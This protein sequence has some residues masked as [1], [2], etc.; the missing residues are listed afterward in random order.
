MHLPAPLETL[1]RNN[2]LQ[3]A[4]WALVIFGLALTGAVAYGQT[5]TVPYLPKYQVLTVVYAP[6]GSASSVTYG[7]SE[8]VGSSQS[9]SQNTTSS[10]NVATT[11]G[12]VWNTPWSGGSIGYTVST[13]YQVQSSSQSTMSIT[14]T[15][16][17][18]VA[19]AGPVSSALGVNHDNDVIYILLNPVVVTT[20]TPGASIPF[21]WVGLQYNSCDLTDAQDVTNVYQAV[22]GCDPNQFPFPDIVGI[23]VWCLKN[24]YYPGTSCTQ[25]LPY[26]SRWWDMVKW[27]INTST[28]LPLGPMLTLQDYADILSV[29]PFVTQTLVP[30]SQTAVNYCHPTYGVNLDPNDSETVSAVP[31]TAPPSGN[32]PSNFCGTPNN[33]STTQVTMQRFDAYDQVQYPEPGIN[34]QPQTYTGTLAYNQTSTLGESATYTSMTGNAFNVSAWGGFLGNGLS[35]SYSSSQSWSTAQGTAS[36]TTSGTANTASYSITGPQLTDNYTGPATF[37]VYKDNV[38]GTFAF[39]SDLQGLGMPLHLSTYPSSGLAGG[40]IN[41][42]SGL[43][44]P[45]S[46]Q[47]PEPP[48]LVSLSS[49]PTTYWAAGKAFSF[50]GTVTVCDPSKLQSGQSCP[51]PDVQAIILTNNSPNQMTMVGPAV[52]FS[53]PGFQIVPGTDNCSDA[54]LLAGG[55]CT[56]SIEFAPVPSDAPNPIH[57]PNSVYANLVA[58]GTENISSYENILVTSTG[59]EV[60]GNAAPASSAGISLFPATI[61]N[62]GVP[63]LYTFGQLAYNAKQTEQFTLT[64]YNTSAV[65]LLSSPADIVLTDSTNFTIT[66]D[67]CSGALLAAATA[68]SSGNPG[69]A[70]GTC[71]FTV[72]YS[73]VGATPATHIYTTTITAWGTVA[74]SSAG[75]LVS[76]GAQGTETNIGISV[77]SLFN[78]PTCYITVSEQ[79]GSCGGSTSITLTNSSAYPVVLTGATGTN[80]FYGNASGTVAAGASTSV[81]VGASETCNNGPSGSCSYN[82]TVTFT[83]TVQSGGSGTS[84][85]ASSS[86]SFGVV[87][88]PSPCIPPSEVRISGAEQSITVATPAKA[89]KAAVTLAGKVKISFT[90]TRH[91]ILTVGG[92]KVTASYNDKATGATVAKALAAAA[93]ASKSPVTATVSGDVVTLKSK[94]AG[95]AGNIAFSTAGSSD[96]AITPKKGS[97]A[98]GTNEIT[99]TEYDAGSVDAAVGSVKASSS[100]GKASTAETIA[101]DLASSLNKAANSAFTATA[102]GNVITITPAAKESKSAASVTVSVNDTKGFKPPSF[103]AST[104][105]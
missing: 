15:Q 13:G 84:V 10:N 35:F 69:V 68:P 58:A 46:S 88:C 79:S 49:S 95:T 70:G 37:N 47:T 96:F 76:A 45:P 83:G 28:S 102:K 71:S 90:G 57:N 100:W 44:Y 40:T 42:Y 1:I 18:S 22:G 16:G 34:G 105:N 77:T 20:A 85:S 94:V 24:P 56:I 48:I 60:T 61:Q 43:Y 82:G 87:F 99:T 38:F 31:T 26:T 80:G 3:K 93:N 92:F 67:G 19:T 65:T 89:G 27:G 104:G 5:Y 91:V 98:G 2:P 30:P 33:G 36:Q 50:S 7:N 86:G 72:Q 81:G 64:N 55:T 78:V 74:G 6:P 66:S 51:A 12:A 8:S 9:I 73:P 62:A 75:P 39:Y 97:L 17:N 4:L 63:S 21:S 14:T 54:V 52:T 101:G 25:W 29:D 11:V 41:K 103:T 53:D 32:W 59:L 23:P